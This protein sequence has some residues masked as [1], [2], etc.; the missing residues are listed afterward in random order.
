MTSAWWARAAAT[1]AFAVVVALPVLPACSSD[2]DPSAG[3]YCDRAK[4]S[5]STCK[6][7]TDCDGALAA[8][9]CA[10]LE[11]VVSA[12][13]LNAARDC[14]ESGVCGP[15]SC[16]SRAQK[17]AAPTPAHKTLAASF[18]QFCAPNVDNCEATFYARTGKL[19]GRLV[20]PYSEEIVKAVDDACTGTDGCQ[21]SFTSCAT[22]VLAQAVG[23]RVDETLASCVVTGFT[24]DEG[25]GKGPGGGA[26][27]A[28]CTA[29]NCK[30]CC[31]EDKC[32]EGK[33]HRRL[34]S[35]R[36]GV[37]DLRGRP[38]VHRRQVQGALRSQQLRR[39]L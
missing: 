34:R 2:P 10:S 35:Q 15:A 28:T 26:Q 37:S 21:A 11:K 32:E 16:L 12:A 30:G 17:S 36:L 4:S 24:Q 22:D 8:A 9:S 7:P 23:E 13:T 5:A 19:P 20:L 38:A 18:C 1:A 14:L 25:E 3:T 6:E 27:V 31:R 33:D 39:L 29:A